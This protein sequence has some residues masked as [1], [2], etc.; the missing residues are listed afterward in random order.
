MKD[1]WFEITDLDKFVAATRTLVY[2]SFGSKSI[3]KEE[4]L[5]TD[6][7]RLTLEEKKEI[8]NCL[9]QEESMA[10]VMDFIRVRKTKKQKYKITDSRYYEFIEAL[11]ARMVSNI[12]N[13]L[14]GDGL[15]ESA[16]DEESNDFIFWVKEEDNNEKNNT[17]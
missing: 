6:P 2:T 17:K 15:L 8:N 1:Q 13:K 3:S 9:S 4:K 10:I 16:F 11:N 7:D 14:S 12:L 5:Q